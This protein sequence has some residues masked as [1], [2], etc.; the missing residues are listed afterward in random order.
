MGP[1][2]LN[3]AGAHVRRARLQAAFRPPRLGGQPMRQRG[4]EE[5]AFAA[6]AV[7][8]R[9]PGQYFWRWLVFFSQL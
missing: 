4:A 1:A 9:Q 8:L 5:D 2:C 3:R 7:A 6:L